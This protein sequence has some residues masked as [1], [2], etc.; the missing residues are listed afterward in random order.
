MQHLLQSICGEAQFSC[1]PI[2]GSLFT[3][4]I[5]IETPHNVGCVVDW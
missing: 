3:L 2:S 4:Y 5:P 1:I